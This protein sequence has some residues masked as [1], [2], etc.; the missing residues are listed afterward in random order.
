MGGDKLEF[1]LNVNSWQWTRGGSHCPLWG[2]SGSSSGSGR[3]C[4]PA[5]RDTRQPQ[6][7]EEQNVRRTAALPLVIPN[8][9][10][11]TQLDLAREN[12]WFQEAEV[13]WRMNDARF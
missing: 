2:R 4:C 3:P 12:E 10:G 9:D 6:R 7:A 11:Q 13:Y 1:T 8:A 5:P